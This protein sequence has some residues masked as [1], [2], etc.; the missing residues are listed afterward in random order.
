MGR[1]EKIVRQFVACSGPF[2]FRDFV[3]MIA[4]LGYEQLPTGKTGGSRRKYFNK[5]T[6]HILML[7][8]PHDGEMGPG[9]VRRLQ[10]ELEERGVL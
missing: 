9:M 6:G 7:D 1:F 4:E 5:N 10:R 2:A 3:K 8:E